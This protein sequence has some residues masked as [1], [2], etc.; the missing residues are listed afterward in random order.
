MRSGDKEG[1]G[2][3]E[4]LVHA[5]TR[6]QRRRKAIDDAVQTFLESSGSKVDK[7]ADGLVRQLEVRQELL[8]VDRCQLLH[9]VR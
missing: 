2:T 7:Q 1:G 8:A 5:E 3:L 9:S 4:P 6:R